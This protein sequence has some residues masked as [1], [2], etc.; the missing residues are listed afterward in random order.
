MTDTQD[1]AAMAATLGQAIGLA[2]QGRNSY[3]A[4]AGGV[5]VLRKAQGIVQALRE[6]EAVA[7]AQ[8][9]RDALRAE[10]LALRKERDTLRQEVDG[11][12]AEVASV[13]AKYR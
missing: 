10:V 13:L 1:L 11:L 9:E 3:Q 4:F 5:E 6:S 12:K 2:E 7:V 8:E